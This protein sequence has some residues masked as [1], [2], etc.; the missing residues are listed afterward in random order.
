LFFVAVLLLFR[1]AR[2][3][4]DTRV[5]WLSAAIFAGS[6]LYWKFTVS[7]LST[8]WLVVVFL[9]AVLALVR[10]AG[11]GQ[12]ARAGIGIRWLLAAWAGLLIGV[13]G[14]SRYAFGWMIIPVL[15]FIGWVAPRGR[16]K[17][18]CAV[19]GA[20]FLIVLGPWM[21]RN[22]VS[23][24]CFGTAELR[25]AAANAAISGRHIGAFF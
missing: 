20:A 13:G 18:C 23:G 14:L 17:L 9:A 6:N 3:M 12:A 7:G 25:G 24:N 16:A 22:M 21:T 11:A 1:I 4:F 15:L 10:L 5:A 8:T 19:A 2:R